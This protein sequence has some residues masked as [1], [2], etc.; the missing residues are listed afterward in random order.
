MIAF[1]LPFE[2][3]TIV[4]VEIAQ[5][6]CLLR[7]CLPALGNLII[8]AARGIIFQAALLF[9]IIEGGQQRTFSSVIRCSWLPLICPAES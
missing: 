6:L 2:Q 7:D 1:D 3:P 4:L 8:G 9:Q 5:M